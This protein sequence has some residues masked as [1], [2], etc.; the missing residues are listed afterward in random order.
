V[1]EA[2][3]SPHRNLLLAGALVV[4]LYIIA[5]VRDLGRASYSGYWDNDNTVIR[6]FPESP[7]ARAGLQVND[8]I[9]SIGGLDVVDTKANARRPR[10]AIGETRTFVTERAGQQATADL[11]Y[12]PLP[13]RERGL[14]FGAILIAACFLVC[15]LSAYLRSPSAATLRLALAGICFGVWLGGGPYIEFYELRRLYTALIVT[16]IV[17]GFAFLLD[18]ILALPRA[19]G[20]TAA[21]QRRA[22]VYGPA[23][24]T[25]AWFL[26]LILAEP[27]STSAVNQVTNVIVGVFAG[28]YFVAALVALVRRYQQATAVERDAG[29]RLMTSGTFVGLVPLA[30]VWLISAVAPKLVLPGVEFYFLTLLLVPISLG[31]GV[32]RLQAASAAPAGQPMASPAG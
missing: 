11:T 7:A 21:P 12:G 3:P 23:A 22:L 6:V 9:R 5:G 4:A 29:L 18:F 31:L 17:C 20:A 24:V 10:A 25:A 19:G 16:L 2:N 1:P 13:G 32:V 26:V 27:P 28:G 14:G 8:R 15:G 30:V